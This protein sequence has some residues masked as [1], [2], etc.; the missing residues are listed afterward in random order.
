MDAQITDMK[1]RAALYKKLHAVMTD[2]AYIKKDAKNAFHQYTY[3]SEAAIKGAVHR[4][5]VKHGIV[6]LMSVLDVHE[7]D[8]APTAKGKH[9]WVT[10]CT[11]EFEFTD[12][13]TG[14]SVAKTFSGQG[15]DGEDKGLP[16]AVTNALKYCLTSALLLETGDDPEAETDDGQRLKGAQKAQIEKVAAKMGTNKEGQFDI[17]TAI[18][19]IGAQKKRLCAL[20][21]KESGLR[22]YYEVLKANGVEHA[23][24]KKLMADPEKA[25]KLWRD[26]QEC[27]LFA[28]N[29]DG[30]AREPEP[31]GYPD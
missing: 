10:R 31:V 7:R 2:I 8:G 6:F 12:I 14:Y 16:K 19:A 23:N 25:R 30:D 18:T 17:T 29:D 21:G 5:F 28:S 20:I 3:A 11:T 24:D 26:L 15:I 22:K 4:A 9:Q 13:D 1:D 27:V